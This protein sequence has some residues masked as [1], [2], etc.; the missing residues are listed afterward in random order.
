MNGPIGVRV[1]SAEEVAQVSGGNPAL[2]AVWSA[3]LPLRAVGAAAGLGWAVGS[4]IYRTY[5]REIQAGLR[6]A[7][8]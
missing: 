2:K 4:A 3:S 7:L 8:D 1:L 6:W 5:D